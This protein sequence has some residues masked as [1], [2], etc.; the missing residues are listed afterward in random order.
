MGGRKRPK[1]RLQED[2]LGS[3]KTQPPAPQCRG[4]IPHSVAFTVFSHHRPELLLGGGTSPA[5]QLSTLWILTA[6]NTLPGCERSAPLIAGVC[7]TVSGPAPHWSALLG[8]TVGKGEQQS[9]LLGEAGAKSLMFRC[10]R[11]SVITCLC[12]KYPAQRA[13][14]E[15]AAGS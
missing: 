11:T 8:A 4:P 12:P 13:P 2:R 9:I 15:N 10:A 14:A 1:T 7:R 5:T 6:L 3:R